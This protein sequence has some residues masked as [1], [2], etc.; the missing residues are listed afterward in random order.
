MQKHPG[1]TIS[2]YQLAEFTAKP[3]MIAVSTENLINAFRKTGIHPF[4]NNVISDV[5]VAPSVI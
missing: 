5:Q 2:K 1:L 3:Y 4:N